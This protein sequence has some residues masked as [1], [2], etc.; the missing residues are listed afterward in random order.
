MFNIQIYE[1]ELTPLRFVIVYYYCARS[2]IEC[3]EV[4]KGGIH[5]IGSAR[6]EYEID[7][8]ALFG[9]IVAAVIVSTID[10]KHSSYSPFI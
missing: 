5:Y 7:G 6:A 2:L 3:H 4:G 9:D 10:D 8:V 1:G